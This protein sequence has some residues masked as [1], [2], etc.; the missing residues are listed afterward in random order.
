MFV[1]LTRSI[2]G[3]FPRGLRKGIYITRGNP[4]LLPQKVPEGENPDKCNGTYVDNA[5]SIIIFSV[6]E[7]PF[8]YWTGLSVYQFFLFVIPSI[9]IVKFLTI[10]VCSH[11]MCVYD[12]HV[13][14]G[15]FIHLTDG[16]QMNK[17]GIR[18]MVN[19]TYTKWVPTMYVLHLRCGECTS[20][21]ILPCSGWLRMVDMIISPDQVHQ[22][23][24]SIAWWMFCIC[25]VSV[26]EVCRDM[27]AV[28]SFFVGYWGWSRLPQC[29]SKSDWKSSDTQAWVWISVK[30]HDMEYVF[31]LCV[32]VGIIWFVRKQYPIEIRW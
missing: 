4:Y 3:R 14:Y 13:S 21:H 17:T 22:T 5:L 19:Q 25:A 15:R 1:L 28:S 23:D 9:L 12:F 2:R 6:L 16:Y 31:T 27:Y 7:F 18:Y 24:G 29:L 30:S 20:I 10:N 8:C 32:G 11:F 26:R